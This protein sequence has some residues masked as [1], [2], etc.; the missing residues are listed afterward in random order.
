MPT[1]AKLVAG[2][3]F[4]ALGYAIFVSM[5]TV[6]ADDRVPEYL[7]PLCL[8]AG[9]IVG[10]QIC[11][12]N[13]LGL[14]SGVGNGYTAIVA[15][16]FVILFVLSFIAMLQ[17]SLRSRYDGPTDAMIDS[18][19]LLAEYGF[20]FATPE[21]GMIMAVGGFVGGAL[22]GIAGRRFPH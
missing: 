5:V 19:T 20:R 16:V 7:L 1:A 21:I 22:A 14:M 12:K 18:F 17:R 10:W 9:L 13:A 15:Q 4:A 8:V 11:G 3:V 6:Y 2:V